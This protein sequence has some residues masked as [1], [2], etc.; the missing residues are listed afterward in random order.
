M[1]HFD[2]LRPANNSGDLQQIRK[3]SKKRLR[4]PPRFS[5][6]RVVADSVRP[7][8]FAVVRGRNCEVHCAYSKFKTVRHEKRGAR[9]K[10][11]F[12]GSFG[13]TSHWAADFCFDRYVRVFEFNFEIH[14]VEYSLRNFRDDGDKR[15]DRFENHG[16]NIDDNNAEKTPSGHDLFEEGGHENGSFVHDYSGGVFGLFV[17]GQ[18]EL[19][20]QYRVSV[21]DFSDCF[22]QKRVRVHF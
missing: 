6:N 7:F 16:K 19:E 2:I 12:Y 5:D 13:A 11:E 14:T 17:R 1:L 18:G 21:D 4:L 9:P 22:G 15:G 3:Q 8:R 20:H 10:C